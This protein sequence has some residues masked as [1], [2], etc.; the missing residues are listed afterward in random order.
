MG[1]EGWLGIGWDSMLAE[2]VCVFTLHACA[3][4]LLVNVEVRIAGSD[5]LRD[6][7]WTC[8]L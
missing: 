4:V 7:W 6:C 3:K 1:W 2:C 8:S 5:C